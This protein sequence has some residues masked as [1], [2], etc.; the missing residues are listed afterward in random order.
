MH[1][2]DTLSTFATSLLAASPAAHSDHLE[3][4]ITLT[5][6]L[7]AAL[8][9]G[10][11]THRVGLS[12]IV[13]YL[14]AGIA[15]GPYTPG[16]EANV[17]LAQQMAEIGVILLMFGVGLHF[18]FKEL[19]AVRR[20]AV[21]GAVGQS[22]IATG[23]G[24]VVAYFF[25]W[26]V[27]SGLVFGMAISVASTVVLLRVLSDNNDLHTP[28]GHIAV[29][30]LVVEDLF[31]VLVL[32]LMPVLFGSANSSL[33]DI[34]LAILIAVIKIG[35]LVAFVMFVGGKAIPWFLARIAQ[36]RSRELF[37]LTVL[38]VALGIAVGAAKVFD[39]SMALGAFLAGMVVGRSDFSSRAASEA[40]P[41][42]DA[43]AVLFFV[44]VGM[45]FDPNQLITSPG[46]IA[47]TLGIVLLGKPL[48]ALAIVILLRYPLRIGLSVAV[49]LAQIGEFSFILA[50]VGMSLNVFTSQ[51]YNA[52]IAAAIVS[53]SINPILYRLTDY[54][55]ERAK[56]SPRLWKL[57]NGNSHVESTQQA[58][59][60]EHPE[61]H[62]HG[63]AVV[64]GYG[65]VGR[66]LCRLLQE[67]GIEPTVIEMNL[68]TVRQL[69]EDG[70]RAVYGDSAHKETQLE[71]GTSQA[72]VFILS[73]SGLR[74]SQEVIR[75]ARECNPK[76]RVFARA[77]YLREIP[78]LTRAGADVVFTGEGEVAMSMTEFILRQM[79]AGPEQI[80]R[81]RDRIRN[82][83][84]GSAAVLEILLPPT[85]KPMP[86]QPETS[87]DEAL[88]ADP[89]T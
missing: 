46:L 30:W 65:P 82:E 13:G 86:E 47:A 72:D 75:L 52:L 89:T 36:T 22:L 84:F 74:N 32:V 38:V 62:D 71:A 55:E 53:I 68:T 24:V 43:F 88:P 69:R 14:L 57:I 19:L 59:D 77:S 11:I 12:P 44:S 23:L 3:L 63:Q 9:M 28:T 78:S 29:G 34:G 60:D 45:L 25:G 83:L 64:I 2:L 17:E 87:A 6:G 39:V 35:L 4:I 70:M 58:P 20:V 80:D 54:L 8:F 33:A 73:A 21:P 5:S 18:H 51:Q 15:V 67:N 85:A 7:A 1:S 61:K 48:A 37:T 10:Y 56:K 49:A 31:T 16:V 27:S 40:L 76:I 66:T 26:T 50:G 81:E 79:G 42:R 41:M